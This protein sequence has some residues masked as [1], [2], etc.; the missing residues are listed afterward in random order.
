M[1]LH[2]RLAHAELVGAKFGDDLGKPSR[3]VGV[4]AVGRFEIRLELRRH[5]RRTLREVRRADDDARRV[6]RS[7]GLVP[8][9]ELRLEK[10]ILLAVRL[11]L[12]GIAVVAD[13]LIARLDA[14]E[15]RLV[16]ALV[17]RALEQPQLGYLRRVRLGDFII[18]RNRVV[19]PSA[20]VGQ[21]VALVGADK[22]ELGRGLA[23]CRRAL[24][25]RLASILSLSC[26]FHARH[27]TIFRRRLRNFLSPPVAL[28]VEILRAS[29][30]FDV[31]HGMQDRLELI[32]RRNA[33]R[34]KPL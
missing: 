13:Q 22:D 8:V 15:L 26:C 21:L 28:L 2:R 32:D 9:H 33:M 6:F 3:E 29:R 23:L 7:L 18:V 27:C 11:A 20:P 4:V 25:F 10:E 17:L 16:A 5:L 34:R 14:D 31:L 1:T 30:A 24:V 12:G 19:V